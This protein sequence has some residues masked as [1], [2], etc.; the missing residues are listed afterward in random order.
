M[1]TV[2][3]EDAERWRDSMLTAGKFT[4]KTGLDKLAA[5]RA[6]ITWGQRQSKNALFPKRPPFHKFGTPTVEDGTV[7]T[8]PIRL[9]RPA[10]SFERHALKQ[11]PSHDGGYLGC[12]LFRYAGGEALQLEKKDFFQ[13]QQVVFFHIRVGDGAARRQERAERFR[14]PLP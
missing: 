5:I 6:E 10:K 7:Q 4:R 9:S 13:V 1:A 3:L 2:T 11:T 12:S 14:S 8:G